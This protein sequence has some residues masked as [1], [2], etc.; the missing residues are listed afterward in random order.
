MLTC[1]RTSSTPTASPPATASRD[2]RLRST[3]PA[4]HPDVAGNRRRQRPTSRFRKVPTPRRHASGLPTVETVRIPQP[5]QVSSPRRDARVTARVGRMLGIAVGVC[6]VTGMISH[7]HQHPVGW[8]PLPPNPAWGYQVTQGA[9]VA[10]GIAVRPAGPGQA[11]QRLP[12]A[13]AVAAGPRP[14]ARARAPVGRGPGV[15]HAVRGHHRHPE[16]RSVVPVELLLPRRPL[17]RRVGPGRVDP[18][19]PG[20]Q[21][22]RHRRARCAPSLDDARAVPGRPRRPDSSR[23]AAR[24]RWLRWA[25]SPW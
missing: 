8:L 4:W 24:H 11:V 19:A 14:Q 2:G 22:R 21:G 16:H 3:R 15:L 13:A 20:G 5:P 18:A 12:A 25:R 9:H 6:F 23:A 7:L 17:R 1:S 10:F